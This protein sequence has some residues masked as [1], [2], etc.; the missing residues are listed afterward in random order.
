MNRSRT[1]LLLLI[2]ALLVHPAAPDAQVLAAVAVALLTCLLMAGVSAALWRW[3]QRGAA[4]GAAGLTALQGAVLL[5][6]FARALN[7]W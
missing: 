7:W 6:G 5:Q 4:L 2:V 3:D 1:S